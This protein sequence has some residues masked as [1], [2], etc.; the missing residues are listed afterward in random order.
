MRDS[1]FF[2][3]I[4]DDV[5]DISGEE[6]LPVLVRFADV[7]HNLREKF[8]GFPPYEADAEISHYNN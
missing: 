4:T 7:A 2:F 5:V 8:V 1:H 3:I 6:H